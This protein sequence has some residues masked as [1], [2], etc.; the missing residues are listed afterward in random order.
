[1]GVYRNITHQGGTEYI[2]L[3]VPCYTRS[4]QDEEKMFLWDKEIGRS[5]SRLQ[6]LLRLER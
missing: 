3:S 6:I 1:M 2:Q 5:C 4:S